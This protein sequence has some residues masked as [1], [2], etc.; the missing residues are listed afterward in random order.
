VR[1]AA[2]KGK[3]AIAP[4][5][6]VPLYATTMGWPRHAALVVASVLVAYLMLFELEFQGHD[7]RVR[8]ETALQ[9]WGTALSPYATSLAVSLPL[10]AGFGEAV[11]DPLPAVVQEVGVLAF[12]ASIGASGAT[13]V[14]S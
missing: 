14:L 13:V 7:L 8:R 9:Q 12:P 4:T 11:A 3:N 2:T 6:E 10:L 1:G 5:D